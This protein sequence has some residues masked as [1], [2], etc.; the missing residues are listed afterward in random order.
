MPNVTLRTP[1][2]EG[3]LADLAD[4]AKR[5]ADPYAVGSICTVVANLIASAGSYGGTNQQ[6]LMDLAQKLGFTAGF[7]PGQTIRVS[8]EQE[9]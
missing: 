5:C 8:R 6:R 3:M 2:A 9:N 4:A 1:V 7:Y